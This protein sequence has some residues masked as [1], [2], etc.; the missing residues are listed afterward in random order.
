MLST[1]K[2]LPSMPVVAGILQEK[3]SRASFLLRNAATV[4]E[5]VAALKA[6]ARTF[7]ELAERSDVRNVVI[8]SIFQGMFKHIF[9]TWHHFW[10]TS[11][12]D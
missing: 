11:G 7:G 9:E 12:A 1:Y 3:W 8:D 2:V 10:V 4:Q 6:W 5:A